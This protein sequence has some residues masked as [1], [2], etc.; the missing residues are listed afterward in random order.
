MKNIDYEIFELEARYDARLSFYGKAQVIV[1][2]EGDKY[3]KSYDTTVALTE[4]GAVYL[5]GYYSQTTTRHQK[6]FYKQ[7][8]NTGR[9]WDQVKKDS[10]K[11][12]NELENIGA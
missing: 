9:T 2:S 10:E 11:K 5:L 8:D 7:F 4:K 1:D 3:L 6:E 12:L